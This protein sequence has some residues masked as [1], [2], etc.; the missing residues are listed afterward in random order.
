MLSILRNVVG[1]IGN[2]VFN[3]KATGPLGKEA[4]N[5]KTSS[6]GNFFYNF[7]NR[8]WYFDKVYNEFLNQVVLRLGYHK[9]FKLIDRGVIE[10]LGPFG[11]SN[12]FYSN[13]MKLNFLQTGLIYHSALMMLVGSISLFIFV[14]FFS[15]LGIYLNTHLI[16]IFIVLIFFIIYLE[17]DFNIKL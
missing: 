4:Y 3:A 9:T 12:L 14:G 5:Y 7:F 8:K 13:T 11:I 10:N 17:K 1:T 6:W 2:W 16:A 15:Y